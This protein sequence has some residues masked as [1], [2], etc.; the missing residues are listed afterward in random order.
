MTLAIAET[1]SSRSI[2][3]P[4][5]LRLVLGPISSP[6]R[7]FPATSSSALPGGGVNY[8]IYAQQSAYSQI[9]LGVPEFRAQYS[10]I[11]KDLICAPFREASLH[12]FLDALEPVLSDALAADPNNQ[13]GG[14]VAEFFAARKTWFSQRLLAVAAQIGGEPCATAGVGGDTAPAA[15]GLA[16]SLRENPAHDRLALQVS[17][18]DASPAFLELFDVTGRKIAERAVEG[19]GVGSHL[20]TIGEGGRLASGVYLVRLTHR[21]RSLTTRA[22]VLR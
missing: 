4:H 19:L 12:A 6:A 18:P 21:T 7:W 22:A 3:S 16:L 5:P 20:V 15:P 14:S 17:L 8:N 13:I 1:V 11:M 10:Q 9:L 2:G